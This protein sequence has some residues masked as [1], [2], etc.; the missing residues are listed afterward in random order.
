MVPHIPHVFDDLFH[1]TLVGILSFG[2]ILGV[3]LA[4]Q[5]QLFNK[6]ASES[7]LVELAFE[8]ES[9]NV[10]SGRV[11]EAKVTIN[12]KAERVTAV[13]LSLEY[14]PTAITIVETKN[15]GFLPVTLK[16]Q[17]DFNGRLNLVYGSTIESQPTKPGVVATIKFKVINYEASRITM[18]G[19]TQVSVS[20]KD[21]NALSMFPVLELQPSQGVSETGEEDLRYQNTLLEEKAV[22][23]DAQPFVRDFQ[24]ALEPKPEVKP[25]RISPQFSGAY[26]K[27]LGSDIFI[28]PVTALNQV[29]EEKAGELIN[30]GEK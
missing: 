29:I 28:A 19:N 11:Y 1:I 14:N 30:R 24:E 9:L 2:I 8:P 13:Q 6:K 10:Q 17:D 23:Q 7:S 25:E 22:L 5:P 18:K 15:E 20:S 21:G 27:Q 3:Y 26:L 4:M 12:P 16:V